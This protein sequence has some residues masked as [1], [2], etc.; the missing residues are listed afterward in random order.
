MSDLRPTK[1]EITWW[2][3]DTVRHA[4]HIEYFLQRLQIGT[5]DKQRPHDIVGVGNKLEWEAI[6]GFALQYR[7]REMFQDHV[8]PSLEF[9]RQQDHHIAWN[10]Y[11]P[12]ASPDAMKLGAVDA[13]CS[14]LEPRDYQGGCHTYSELYEIANNNP[15][16]KTG[17]ML[18]VAQEMELVEQP[19]LA[20][21]SLD[22][23]PTLGLSAESH[24]ILCGRISECRHML[25][26]D[27]GIKV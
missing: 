22:N 3:T 11:N 4:Y 14:L 20:N 5:E 13:C 23:V 6:R 9:H 25:A 16:H 17:W 26:S 24:D 21:I 1:E 2:L 12:T 10:E 19:V 27:H 8:L 7:G 15:I 18:L